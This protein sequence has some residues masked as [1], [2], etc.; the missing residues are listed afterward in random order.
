MPDAV[1]DPW[2]DRW[3]TAQAEHL[4]TIDEAFAPLPVLRAHLADEEV[5]GVDRL[6]RFG[7]EVYRDVDPL[8][9]LHDHEPMRV[10]KKGD[11]DYRLSLE[12]PFAERDELDV[13]RRGDELIVIVG[14]YRRCAAAARLAAP[15]RGHRSHAAQGSPSG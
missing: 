13:G 12:L 1:T 14:P 4:A 15:P 9:V 6:R 7:A 11:D 8:A 2:F 10:R 5:V 3:R